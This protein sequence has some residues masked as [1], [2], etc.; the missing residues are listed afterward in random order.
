MASTPSFLFVELAAEHHNQVRVLEHVAEAVT[1]AGGEVLGFA[2]PGRVACLE[3]GT[4]A[5]GI[6]LARFAD[7]GVAT[8]SVQNDL[9]PVL[10]GALPDGYVPTVYLVAGLPTTGLPEMLAIPTV[11][12]VPVPPRVPRNSLMVIRGSVTNQAQLDLYRDVILPMIKERKGYYEVF[13]LS[14][15]EVTVICGEWRDQIFAVSRWPAAAAAADFWYSDRYQQT[16]IPLRL[17]Y[18]RFA[19]HLFDAV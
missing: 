17:G 4:V 6:L 9:L 11:A 15:G 13:A 16:A 14:A 3:P 12:S 8:R 5:A 7:A 19:V 18:G 10:R 2:A 1:R